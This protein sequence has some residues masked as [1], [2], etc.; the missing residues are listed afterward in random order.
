[1]SDECAA[2]LS[3][4]THRYG[5]VVAL[6]GLDLEIRSV[7]V[8]ALLGPNGA[9]KT[10]AV[11]LLLGSLQVQG[12]QG[13]RAGVRPGRQGS[14][15]AVRRHAAGLRL[16]V[17]DD[18]R[19]GSVREGSG[20]AGMRERVERVRGEMAIEMVRGVTLTVRIPADPGRPLSRLPASR[21]AAA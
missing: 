11:G 5:D 17:E 1:M 16:T 4:V 12:G 18:G 19:G 6:D 20:L 2:T 8:L 7:E 3:S 15:Y 13:A 9:G 21:E 10:T 14:S